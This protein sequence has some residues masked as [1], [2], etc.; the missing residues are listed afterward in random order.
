MRN[1]S[2]SVEWTEIIDNQHASVRSNLARLF[3]HGYLVFLF[4]KRDFIV[5]YKQTVFGPLWMLIQP[6]LTMMV[7]VIIFSKIARIP[8]DNVPPPLFYISGIIIWSFF[9]T[10]L[11]TNANIFN[12]NAHIFGKIYF[13]RL[14]IP[15]SRVLSSL[16]GYLIQL[17]IFIVIYIYYSSQASQISPNI[18]LL[19]IPLI[20]LLLA[21]IS[22]G[23]GLLLSSLISKY[24]DL[25]F[26]INFGLQLLMFA[27]PVIYPMSFVPQEYRLLIACNPVSHLVEYYKFSLFSTG[28]YDLNGL[29]Y[30]TVF[31]IVVLIAGVLVFNKTET[32]FID[33]I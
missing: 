24:R 28:Q 16:T 6:L 9:S 29:L 2:A 18:H 5:R 4:F 17:A 33:T 31:A 15:L 22:L 10:N 14:V 23:T 13:P 7:Y 8:T 1:E 11:S 19:C 21:M 20:L 32:R 12:E 26:L 27:T 30:S 3:N 25:K